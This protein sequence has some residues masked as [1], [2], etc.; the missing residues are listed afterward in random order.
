M[1]IFT[2]WYIYSD[3]FMFLNKIVDFIR[4]YLQNLIRSSPAGVY[5]KNL[6][7]WFGLAAMLQRSTQN[8]DGM[9]IAYLTTAKTFYILELD[10]C[11]KDT[12]NYDYD[13]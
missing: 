7:K 12:D 5:R 3:S 13:Y 4:K 11:I 8:G 2:S 10:M 6:Y 9:A 1:F